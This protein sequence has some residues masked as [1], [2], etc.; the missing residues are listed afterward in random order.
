[1]RHKPLGH[2]MISQQYYLRRGFEQS[3]SSI[4]GQICIRSGHAARLPAEI[5]RKSGLT[6]SMDDFLLS[7]RLH[8]ESIVCPARSM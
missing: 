2:L 1:V 5:D 4:L 6:W 3:G 8:E 7:N